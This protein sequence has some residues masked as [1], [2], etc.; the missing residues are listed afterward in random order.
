MEGSC[1]VTPSGSLLATTSLS[2]GHALLK[3]DLESIPV[4]NLSP[5]TV[6]LEKGV[7]L[8]ILEKH[9]EAKEMKE[10][11][12]ILT[13]DAS[14]D[15]DSDAERKE[16]LKHLEGEIG[17]NL[18]RKEKEDTVNIL[19][20]F[21][22]CI[23]LNE[24]DLGYSSAIEHNINAANA[25]AQELE[26]HCFI[27]GAITS[28]SRS[29]DENEALV[30]KQ[31]AFQSCTN[32]VLKIEKNYR[33]LC[34]PVDYREII[35]Q[36]YHDDV[37]SGHLGINRTLH[38]IFNRS[39]WPKM[40]FDKIRHVQKGEGVPNKSPGLLQC[41]KLEI[42][43][44]KA[45]IN[46]P[47]ELKAMPTGIANNVAECFVN[48]ILL[49]HGAPEQII[50]DR[51][52]CFTS[53]LTQAV[54]NK[55]HTNHKTT[56]SCY[57][58]AKGAME[59]MNHRLASML[60]IYGSSDQ[61]DWDR[62]LQCSAETNY[63]RELRSD[64]GNRPRE[65]RYCSR[66]SMK[67]FHEASLEWQSPQTSISDNTETTT[68]KDQQNESEQQEEAQDL[69]VSIDPQPQT[70]E[71]VTVP[72][73][74]NGVPRRKN[75]AT[76]RTD[77]EDPELNHFEYFFQLNETFEAMNKILL[78]LQQIADIFDISFSLLAN[79]HLAP[80]IFSPAKF[81][82]VIKTINGQ[83][84]RGWSISSDE[85]W[86]AYRESTVSVAA[87]ENSFRLFIHVPLFDHAQQ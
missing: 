6:W 56:S 31:K 41:I 11:Q 5:K 23:A 47:V 32:K 64:I 85:L 57:P 61:C 30:E 82:K 25:N 13:I 70:K 80:Q 66:R 78:W 34:V 46:L 9:P 28:P 33:R 50:S 52:K 83:L 48:Q 79:W 59:K 84:P 29:Q 75:P 17:E 8:G 14:V 27:G 36:A 69:P 3:T 86:V 40:A 22:Y 43:F 7:T 39:F 45:G 49:R 58:Q 63:T 24:V 55:L 74:I 77:M 60:S 53:D 12:G 15:K 44:Q 72:G 62:T 51:G 2:T 76:V 19:K 71:E 26:D 1:I 4:A 73:E 10:T 68:Q 21:I 16:F 37:V 54:A 87:M 18:T 38:K 81:N 20:Q 35:Q 67:S 42:P 65:I